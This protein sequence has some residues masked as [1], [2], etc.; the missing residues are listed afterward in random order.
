M[1]N[2]ITTFALSA[3]LT[4]SF[5]AAALAGD[6]GHGHNDRGYGRG[7]DYGQQKCKIV[8]ETRYKFVTK[9]EHKKEYY[10]DYVNEVCEVPRHIT[11]TLYRE[12]EDHV[13]VTVTDYRYEEVDK[14]GYEVQSY[15]DDYGC[16]KYRK[17]YVPN[18]CK[19]KVPFERRVKK[20]ITR[21]VP[22]EVTRTIYEKVTKRVPVKKFRLVP[23]EVQV[24]V[25]YK[26]ARKVCL[27]D[28][29]A[30]YRG[31]NY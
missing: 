11:D 12:I 19:V 14:G 25:P 17:V 27:D 20:C 18:I 9:I 16:N 5:A 24:K 31:G 23:C 15:C 30:N 22:Y 21:K 13:F 6:Y 10:T 1:I 7:G 26:V 3:V 29:Q 2:R 28:Y 8:Y 4:F